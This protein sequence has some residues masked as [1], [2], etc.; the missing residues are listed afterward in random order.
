MFFCRLDKKRFKSHHDA[1]LGVITYLRLFFPP[2]I[3][4]TPLALIQADVLT[5]KARVP[6]VV[7]AF[8]PVPMIDN[9]SGG[10]LNL[11][12]LKILVIH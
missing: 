11:Q 9:A 3:Q 10:V 12:R 7:P 2:K 5:P 4:F 1:F 8:H 6:I